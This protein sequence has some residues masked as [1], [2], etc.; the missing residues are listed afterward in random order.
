M[1]L[2]LTNDEVSALKEA[3]TQCCLVEKQKLSR[4]RALLNNEFL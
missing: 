1:T 2:E 4:I 3:L